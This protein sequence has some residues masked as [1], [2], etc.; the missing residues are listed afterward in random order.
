MLQLFGGGGVERRAPIVTMPTTKKVGRRC[1]GL[2]T[3]LVGVNSWGW[4]LHCR[5]SRGLENNSQNGDGN[6]ANGNLLRA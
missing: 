4:G 5:R 3:L 6:C 1:V 2:G